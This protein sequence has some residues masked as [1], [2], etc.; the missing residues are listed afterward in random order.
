M[1]N[2]LYKI[3]EQDVLAITE[4][5][6]RR[7]IKENT[8]NQLAK[9]KIRGIW[10][11]LINKISPSQFVDDLEEIVDLDEIYDNLESATGIDRQALEAMDD[12]RL[13]ETIFDVLDPEDIEDYINEIA[14][15]E[16][17][18][19]EEYE[20]DDAM[21]YDENPLESEL[22]PEFEPEFD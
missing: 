12:E 16:N 3:T 10:D 17:I 18:E 1:K 8:G 4:N 11:E 13:L 22:E 15:I 19:L 21:D 6:V 9:N 7:I 2:K 14:Y 20:V 5:I